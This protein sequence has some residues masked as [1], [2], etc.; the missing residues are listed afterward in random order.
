MKPQRRRGRRDQEIRGGSS[1]ARRNLP[2]ACSAPLRFSPSRPRCDECSA[3]PLPPETPQPE[4]GVTRC[5]G[6]RPPP[7]N[8]IAP[9]RSGLEPQ[10]EHFLTQPEGLQSRGR[11]ARADHRRYRAG[12]C[13]AQAAMAAGSTPRPPLACSRSCGDGG[14]VERGAHSSFV[15]TESRR[16]STE[17]RLRSTRSSFVSTHSGSW[18][19]ESASMASRSRF[20]RTHG[21]IQF[22][23]SFS[24]RPK[25]R[26]LRRQVDALYTRRRSPAS[27]SR[28]LKTHSTLEFSK[29]FSHHP[30]RR[31]L[32][33]K[34][35][36]LHTRRRSL[37]SRSRS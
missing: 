15:S 14:F 9:E 28:F 30:K 33:Q 36:A 8:E 32:R 29:S 27:R 5:Q 19:N 1:K 37:A 6:A 2:S 3:R 23:K 35:D 21:I 25:C 22:S 16:E 12:R 10:P 18:S 20:F 4:D 24:H 7:C 26:L 31:L 13:A 34:V 11:R 17:S